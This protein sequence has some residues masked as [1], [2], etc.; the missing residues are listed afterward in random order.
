MQI[1]ESSVLG[2]R[3]ARLRFQHPGGKPS[4][5]LFPMI[6]VGQPEF[7]RAAFDD[8]FAHDLVLVEGV[9]SPISARITRSY[10]W[11]L[12]S[13]R[14]DLSLQ[15]KSPDPGTCHATIIHADLSAAEF[16]VEWR[17]V[18]LWVRLAVY[19]LSPLIGL[20]RRWFATRETIAKDLAMDVQPS[21]KE[22]V[23]W[24]PETGALTHA[25][26]E[27]RDERLVDRLREQLSAESKTKIAIVYG[28]AHMRAV[29]RELTVH[30]GY[31]TGP[32][33]WLTVFHF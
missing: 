3:S 21:Q 28:A 6:H 33:D 17:K 30:Q 11:L 16:A 26:L 2:V 8:A 25:I 9:K 22:L 19:L 29:I 20:Q 14:I 7:Y 5:T 10:R 31:M 23:D 27:S 15:P 24:S 32:S 1:I 12:A 18:Q 13:K 4:V